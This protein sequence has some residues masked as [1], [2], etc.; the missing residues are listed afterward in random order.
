MEWLSGIRWRLKDNLATFSMSRLSSLVWEVLCKFS[1]N[2]L[3]KIVETKSKFVG[4]KAILG[5]FSDF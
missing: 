3:E 4:I 2:S 1:Q 5:S